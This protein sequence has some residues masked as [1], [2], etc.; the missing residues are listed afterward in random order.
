MRVLKW[1]VDRCHGRAEAT[2]TAL[3]W[4]PSPNSFDLEGMEDFDPTRFELAQRI[5]TEEW[6]H[7]ITMQNCSSRGFESDSAFLT[8]GEFSSRGK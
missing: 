8:E 4:I 7:E 6:R 2:E 3:G 1:I 5:N